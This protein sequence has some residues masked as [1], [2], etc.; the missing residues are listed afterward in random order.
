[1]PKHSLQDIKVEVAELR[2]LIRAAGRVPVERDT[3]FNVI[4]PPGAA[5]AMAGSA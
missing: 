1:M 3:L 2:E 4:Q 5:T